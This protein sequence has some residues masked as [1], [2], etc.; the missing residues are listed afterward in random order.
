METKYTLK[1]LSWLVLNASRI[2]IG[3]TVLGSALSLAAP[4]PGGTL[5]PTTVPKYVTPL[6]IPPV[7][8]NTG[9]ANDYDIAVRQFRQQILPGGIWNTVNGRTDA[10][11]ATT[12]WSY[13][14]DS[15]PSRFHGAGRRCRNSTGAKLPVQL[16][17][18]H[19]GKHGQYADHG[20]LDQRPGGRSRGVKA[21]TTPAT[22]PACNYISHLLPIDRS[23]HWAN[24]E[25]LP[26]SRPDQAQGLPSRSC[27]RRDS[28]AALPR[29]GADHHPRARCTHYPGE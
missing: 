16:P 29:T 21:S 5:D 12:V 15:D 27:Q 7:M 19:A 14:P 17:G 2:L 18:L 28:A 4:F 9:T 13:G 26:C 25:Q 23:L 11:P 24:P 22:D 8:N 6:V 20:G 1:Q 3:G 10:F